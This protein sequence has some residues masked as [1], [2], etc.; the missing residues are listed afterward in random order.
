MAKLYNLPCIYFVE[1][2]QYSMGTCIKRHS[3]GGNDLHKKF[4]FIPGIEINGFNVF[5]V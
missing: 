5:E 1:N 2:N 3:S 4:T